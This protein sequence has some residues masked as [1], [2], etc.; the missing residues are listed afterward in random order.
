MK[1]TTFILLIAQLFSVSVTRAQSTP[2]D[3]IL[4]ECSACENS[5]VSVLDLRRMAGIDST[6]FA[7]LG[8]NGMILYQYFSYMHLKDTIC[9][10]I[11]KTPDSLYIYEHAPLTGIVVVDLSNLVSVD[12]VCYFPALGKFAIT[13]NDKDVSDMVSKSVKNTNP[14]VHFYSI[15]MVNTFFSSQKK[16]GRMVYVLWKTVIEK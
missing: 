10:K 9:K 5:L 13:L 8:C 3:C 1:N 11:L 2:D 4:A 14:D 15:D 7:H 12:V 6:Y 16:L